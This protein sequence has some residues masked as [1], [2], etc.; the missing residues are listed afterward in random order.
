M[1]RTTWVR[2][3]FLKTLS[4]ETK[5]SSIERLSQSEIKYT[6]PF[7][8]SFWDSKEYMLAEVVYDD[9]HFHNDDVVFWREIKCWATL[10]HKRHNIETRGS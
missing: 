1:I 6:S 3:H 8:I 5:S 9:L 2:L 10:E 7:L 4:R